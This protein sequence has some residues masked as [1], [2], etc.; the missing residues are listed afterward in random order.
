MAE[1]GDAPRA[2]SVDEVLAA[3]RAKAT[4]RG[5]ASE[6]FEWLARHDPAHE[7][8]RLE[9]NKLIFTPENPAFPVKYR[10]IIL[11]VVLAFRGYPSVGMHLR[12]ALRE[13]ATVQEII[14]A[15]ETAAIPGGAPMLH[16]AVKCLIE[17][18]KE[19]AQQDGTG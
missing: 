5:Y 11:A 15:F 13:G 19:A 17:I 1:S 18:E 6:E 16:Q 12:R 10:E 3:M 14:E 2:V 9:Y 7:M 4:K 8:A